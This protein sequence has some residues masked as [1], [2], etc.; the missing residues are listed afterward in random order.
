MGKRKLILGTLSSGALT[1]TTL[2]A[3]A[4]GTAL[5]VTNNATIG[6]TL[7]VTG[8]TT[9]GGSVTAGSF[10]GPISGTLTGAVVGTTGSFSGALTG[11]SA[12]FSG[13]VGVVGF[14]KVGNASTPGR[15]KFA[16]NNTDYTLL[17]V[18]STDDVT[19]TRILISGSARSGNA[20][21]IQYV[22]VGSGSTHDF[23]GNGTTI[24][25]GSIR[26]GFVTLS[27][28]GTA[29][30][31]TNN[32]TIG[33]TF[34]VTGN[35]TITGGLT[36][37]GA[38]NAFTVTN[39]ATIGGT[40]GTGAITGT[41][42]TFSG[43]V[44]VVGFLKVGNASTPGRL[45]FASSSTDYTLLGVNSSDDATNTRIIIS[46]SARSGNAGVIQYV[47]MGSGSS[48]DFYGNGTTIATGFIRSGS[49][50]LSGTGTVLNLSNGGMSCSG[51]SAFGND[52]ICT[53]KITNG[54][55]DFLLGTSDQT[56]RGNTG[57][58]RALVKTAGGVLT[59]NF[60]GD[61]FGGVYINSPF[62][63]DS[64]KNVK[65]GYDTSGTNG[66]TVTFGSAFA[67][68]P[69]VTTTLDTNTIA[70]MTVYNVTTTA[71]QWVKQTF[72]TANFYWIATNFPNN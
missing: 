44:G 43:D 71:F 42:A 51:A 63:A 25:T 13:D 46:G 37:N 50:T 29:L 59:I 65:S 66:G 9:F 33:G 52:L 14:L 17:G 15:L 62:S 31:V 39:N 3:T 64:C 34:G 38:G 56:T 11:A 32:A 10:I 69:S 7:G 54:G 72:V 23:Y 20:G 30:S 2:T 58:S 28:T 35:T 24:A 36:V 19:N 1:A 53:T 4:A 26:S 16:A 47:S 41:S 12:T 48:H 6:G 68:I 67:S 27:G 61:F 8:T 70:V 5:S 18:N 40:L 49:M 45:K 60:G 21:V 22:S 55:F 57:T